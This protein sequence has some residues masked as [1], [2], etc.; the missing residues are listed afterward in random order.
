M[1]TENAEGMKI[2]FDDPHFPTLQF[3]APQIAN[4]WWNGIGGACISIFFK[5]TWGQQEYVNVK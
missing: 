5:Q 3:V 4:T 1:N 2:G